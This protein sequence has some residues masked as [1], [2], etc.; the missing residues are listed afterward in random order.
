MSCSPVPLSPPPEIAAHIAALRRFAATLTRE[1]AEREDLV[2]DTLLRALERDG[3]AVDPARLRSWLFRIMHNRLIDLRRAARA[4]DRR[5]TG[6]RWLTP[7]HSP[8]AQEQT[9]RLAQI[10]RVFSVLPPEQRRALELVAIEGLSSRRA[11]EVE[12]IPLGTLL[13]RVSRA[14]EALRAYE[15]SPPPQKGAAD[16]P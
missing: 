13:S 8:A 16:A 6:L 4:R 2:Q 11:A 12:N 15:N 7:D 14:R 10:R 5:E 3:P 1:P 9:V